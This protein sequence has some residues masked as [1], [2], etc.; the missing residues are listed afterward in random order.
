MRGNCRAEGEI[1]RERK[2]ERE[3]E[4]RVRDCV[5]EKTLINLTVGQIS[6]SLEMDN[7]LESAFA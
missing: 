3:K 5:A 6:Q 4:K 1:E 2:R 7:P